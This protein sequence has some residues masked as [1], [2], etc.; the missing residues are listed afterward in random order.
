MSG[1]SGPTAG[2]SGQGVTGKTTAG[3][4]GAA[5]PGIERA[6]GVERQG[7]AADEIEIKLGVGVGA[8]EEEAAFP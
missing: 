7:A 4:A 6:A 1:V 8:R 2:V 5:L 3:A